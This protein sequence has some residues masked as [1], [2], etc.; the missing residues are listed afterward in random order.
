MKSFLAVL[1][2]TCTILQTCQAMT[3][4][5][6]AVG[7]ADIHKVTL[8]PDPPAPGDT[9]NFT[10]VGKAQA[11]VESGTLDISVAFSGVEIFTESRDLCT[12]TKCPIT[13]GPLIIQYQ[14]FLPPIV[15]PG[16][17]TVII[18]A[19]DTDKTV[20]LCL[21]VDFDILPPGGHTLNNL[22]NKAESFLHGHTATE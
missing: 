3:W 18:T 22:K 1:V 16:H 19:S 17:Y 13:E 10:I 2:T 12:R 8:S 7:Q 5:P 11:H 20:L 9:V 4:K 15:P 14:Q 6:C 21:A